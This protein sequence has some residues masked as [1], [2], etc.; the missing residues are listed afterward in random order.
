MVVVRDAQSS[1]RLRTRGS[2]EPRVR[3]VDLT[4]A[5]AA[6]PS[7]LLVEVDAI[8][9]SAALAP[10]GV[11]DLLWA[12]G[13]TT[14]WLVAGVGRLLPDRL[15]EVARAEIERADDPSVEVIDL[16]RVDRVAGPNGL[17][18]LDRFLARLDCPVAPELLRL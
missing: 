12:L 17:D 6:S 18:P 16:S 14:L 3:M 1:F 8:C 15:F 2:D 7:H 13:T 9:S 10:E 5:L 4:E 11:S